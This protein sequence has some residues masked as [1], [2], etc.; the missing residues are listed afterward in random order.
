MVFAHKSFREMFEMTWTSLLALP[1]YRPWR[2]IIAF[3][4]FS[5][6]LGAVGLTIYDITAG[7]IKARENERLSVM[8]EFKKDQIE[9]WLA[10]VRADMLVYIDSPF[11]VD[12]L[13][14]KGESPQSLEYLT[15]FSLRIASTV[16]RVSNTHK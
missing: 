10:E 15:Y 8:T 7:T 1:N 9:N 13:V 6:T 5:I 2:L 12:A 4:A 3:I 11:F 16:W 14:K